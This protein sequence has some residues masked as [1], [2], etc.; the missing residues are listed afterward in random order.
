MFKDESFDVIIV[1]AGIGGTIC[2]ALLSQAGFK[3]LLL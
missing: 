2:A 1:G 3:T